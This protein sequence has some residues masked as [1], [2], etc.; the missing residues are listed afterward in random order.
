LH[1]GWWPPSVDFELPDLATVVDI[2]ERQRKE[3]ASHLAP[4]PPSEGGQ[5]PVDQPPI[6]PP[7]APTESLVAPTAANSPEPTLPVDDSDIDYHAEGYNEF[8]NG[9]DPVNYLDYM[10]ISPY[11]A[12]SIASEVFYSGVRDARRHVESSQEAP[13]Q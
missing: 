9:Y 8:I 4:V 3:H 2:L 13:V 5:A 10:P 12:G 11:S 1:C 7:A 6:E